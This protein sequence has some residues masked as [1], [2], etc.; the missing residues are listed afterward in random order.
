MLSNCGPGEDSWVPWT[1]RRSNQSILQKINPEYSLEVLMLKL[2]LQYFGN[3]MRRTDSS[4]KPWCWQWQEEKGAI[5]EEMVGMHHWLK[6]HEFKQAPGVGDRQGSLACCSMGSQRVRHDWVTELNWTEAKG[7]VLITK[8][9]STSRQ[10]PHSL[11][12]ETSKQIN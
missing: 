10:Q 12:G 9:C 3:L 5:E 4:E 6:G 1:T 8:R 7:K 11:V 2:K